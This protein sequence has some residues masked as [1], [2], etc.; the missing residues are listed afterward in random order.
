MVT[1]GPRLEGQPGGAYSI[2]SPPELRCKFLTRLEF[3]LEVDELERFALEGEER[4]PDNDPGVGLPHS[5]PNF[6][7][8]RGTRGANTIVDAQPNARHPVR[9]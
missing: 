4:H 3:G 5:T 9:L 8:Q 7:R 1:T 2:I 6:S